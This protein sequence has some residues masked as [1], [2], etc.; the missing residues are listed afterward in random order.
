MNASVYK[1][2]THDGLAY[3]IKLK[4]NHHDDI[5]I[6]ILSLL[7]SPRIQQIIPPIKTISGR[8]TQ[9]IDDYTLI[10]YPFI[11]RQNGFCYNLTDETVWLSQAQ[12]SEL[13]IKIR[14]PLPNTY[15]TYL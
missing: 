10:V 5:N 8:P 11:E 3:F 7:Q 6:A 14:E 15:R 12:L 2:H 13:L 1:A 9:H 4:R